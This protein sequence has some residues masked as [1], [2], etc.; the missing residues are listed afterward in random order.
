MSIQLNLNDEDIRSPKI[1][2]VGE[3]E[4]KSEL[5]LF[6]CHGVR[7]LNGF[8]DYFLTKFAFNSNGHAR[9]SFTYKD[10]REYNVK[11]WESLVSL[12]LAW[13]CWISARELDEE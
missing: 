6:L 13:D 1:E 2:L 10:E 9:W 7:G 12:N 8:N 5:K 4:Y 3:D 11:D